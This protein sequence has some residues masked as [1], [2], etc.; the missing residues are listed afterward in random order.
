VGGEV[1]RR[2]VPR[3]VW[4]QFWRAVEERRV[5][6]MVQKVLPMAKHWAPEK[7]EKRMGV[8]V[9]RVP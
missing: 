3:V 8:R 7:R 6:R 2:G 1:G 4:Y 5:D 9:W